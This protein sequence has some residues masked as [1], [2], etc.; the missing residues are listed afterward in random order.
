[1]TVEESALPGISV[2]FVE[3]MLVENGFISPYMAADQTRMETVYENPYILMT[4]KPISRVQ[5]LM[6]ALDQVMK[7]PRPLVVLAEK[8]DGAALGMLI[9]N[10][11]HGTLEAV[12]VRAP[13]FGHRRIAHLQDLAVFTG[14]QVITEE[15]G[16]TLEHVELRGSARARRVIVTE[17]STTFIEGARQAEAVDARLGADPRRDRARV[18]GARP[19]GR[20]GAAR[21]ARRAGSRSSAWARPPT[22]SSREAPPH[23][24]RA[25]GEPRGGR[26]GHRARRRHRAAA[27]GGRARRP[28][29]EGDY[30]RGA[31]LVRRVLAEPLFWIATN[32]GYDGRAVI[33]QVRAMPEG[34]GLTR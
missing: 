11:Q 21:Q 7:S 13:G 29:L 3:G 32:A 1:M 5:D 18:P 28:G 16:L 17:D 25:R 31:D 30:A 12:A 24:G 15:A 10:T 4:N 26:R 6:P 20:A 9:Q 34:D 33:D 23:R 2:D 22:S 27:R 8:V 14:G 19:R